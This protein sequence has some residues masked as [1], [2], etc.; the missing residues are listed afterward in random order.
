GSNRGVSGIDGIISTAIGFSAGSGKLCTLLTGDLAFL[1]D[2]N[3]LATINSIKTPVIIVLIN[4]NGGGIFHFLPISKSRDIFED[5]FATP[6][7]LGFKDAAGI[8]KINY[9]SAQTCS[10]FSDIYMN[11]IKIA[12]KKRQSSLIE[13]VTDREYNLK[14]RRKIKTEILKML[15]E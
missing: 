10:G 2:L 4:N 14:L 8:F 9:F 6:H 12:Q 1:H 7:N 13:V 5:Y 11:S 3:A 15:E